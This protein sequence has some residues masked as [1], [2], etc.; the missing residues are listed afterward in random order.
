MTICKS[1]YHQ[2]P[3]RLP[4]TEIF[5]VFSVFG[6]TKCHSLCVTILAFALWITEKSTNS[7]AY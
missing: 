1:K 4:N 7:R 5:K 2:I 6:Q 3:P